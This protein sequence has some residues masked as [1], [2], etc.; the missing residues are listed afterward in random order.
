MLVLVHFISRLPV[1][2]LV[3]QR[4]CGRIKMGSL[5]TGLKRDRDLRISCDLEVC[6]F[7]IVRIDNESLGTVRMPVINR[8]L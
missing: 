4:H 2:K 8:L 1:N 6:L 3:A 5:I 7:S